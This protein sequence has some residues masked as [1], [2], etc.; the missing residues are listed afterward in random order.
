M[1]ISLQDKKS[2]R[3]IHTHTHGHQ[4]GSLLP[5]LQNRVSQHHL[6]K[7]AV[8]LTCHMTKHLG[9]DEWRKLLTK[10]TDRKLKQPSRDLN[11]RLPECRDGMLS[12]HPRR[13]GVQYKSCEHTWHTQWMLTDLRRTSGATQVNFCYDLCQ[14]PCNHLAASPSRSLMKINILKRSYHHLRK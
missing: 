10:Q 12:T 11:R 1:K 14:N 9:H 3:G 13:L 7:D 5:P 2:L 8:T 6:T 4:V